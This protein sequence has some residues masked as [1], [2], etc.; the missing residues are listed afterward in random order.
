MRVSAGERPATDRGVDGEAVGVHR[1]DVCGGFPVPQLADVEVAGRAV[2]ADDALKTEEDV[3]RRLHEPLSLD[4]AFAVVRVRAHARIRLEYRRL[5]L[6]DLQEQRISVVA[7][8]EQRHE[9][10]GA[11]APDT[12]DLSCQVDVAV[13]L[14]ELPP[15]S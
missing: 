7:S 3:A 12:D 14:E 1:F 15:I 11:D 9:R 5:G 4:D 10:A 2:D 6:L 8:D 13:R